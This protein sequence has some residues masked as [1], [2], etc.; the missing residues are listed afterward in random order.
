MQPPSSASQGQHRAVGPALLWESTALNQM[1]K[2]EGLKVTRPLFTGS[3]VCL[4]MVPCT[5]AL[6][7]RLSCH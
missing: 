7:C 5:C 3:C 4:A 2:P 6:C 1:L